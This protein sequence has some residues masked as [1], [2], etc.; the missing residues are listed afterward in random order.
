MLLP[1]SRFVFFSGQRVAHV[2]FVGQVHTQKI[3]FIRNKAERNGGGMCLVESLASG[4]VTL[5]Q[6][7][8]AENV[9]RRGGG[10][11]M[12]SIASLILRGPIPNYVVFHKY[13][14]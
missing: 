9:A 10:L 1:G 11:F 4:S 14:P 12:D 6:S 5:Q 13:S 2:V 8:F 3:S 7:Y